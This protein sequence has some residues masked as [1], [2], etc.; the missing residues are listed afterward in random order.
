MLLLIDL[1]INI[2]PI[3]IQDQSKA[4]N[5]LNNTLSIGPEP[6]LASYTI[7][8]LLVLSISYKINLTP[9]SIESLALNISII[10]KEDIDLTS[11]IYR[12]KDYSLELN[13]SLLLI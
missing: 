4:A 2:A 3:I 13:K 5:L 9:T 7:N 12:V 6:L 8:I 10:N 1:D 11:Y